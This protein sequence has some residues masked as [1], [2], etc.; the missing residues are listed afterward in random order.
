MC[1][2][3]LPVFVRPLE[4]LVRVLSDRLEHQEPALPDRL[5]QAPVD[6]RGDIVER[7]RRRPLG[8]VE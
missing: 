6:E 3:D 4:E 2:G 5:E 8:V 7:G 1:L